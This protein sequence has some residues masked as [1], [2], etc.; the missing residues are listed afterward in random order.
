M[1]YFF[2]ET[3][4]GVQLNNQPNIKE[5]RSAIYEFG[6]IFTHQL[7][8]PW[9][10]IK[11]I[12][13]RCAISEKTNETVK[14]LHD[15]SFNIIQQR[16]EYLKNNKGKSYSEKKRLAMLDLLLKA[17]FEEGVDIDDEGIREEVDTFMFEVNFWLILMYF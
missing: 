4:L 9:L 11:A 15:F 12:Y 17:R 14:T 3:S 7:V 5:Y 6:E 2:S 1:Y 13:N 8:R 10:R 16:K